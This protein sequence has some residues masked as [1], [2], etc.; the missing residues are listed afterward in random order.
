MCTYLVLPKFGEVYLAILRFMS[1]GNS[2]ILITYVPFILTFVY[3]GKLINAYFFLIA[4][5]GFFNNYVP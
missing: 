2:L 3:V 1:R 4:C 5:T